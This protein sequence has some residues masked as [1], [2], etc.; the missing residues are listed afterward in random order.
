MNNESFALQS[1]TSKTDVVILSR[2]IAPQ[3]NTHSLFFSNP[4]HSRP[5]GNRKHDFSDYIHLEQ[6]DVSVKNAR[7]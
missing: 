5:G 7:P 1:T 4:M 3:F 2:T 6:Q